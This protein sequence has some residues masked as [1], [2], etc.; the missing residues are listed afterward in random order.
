MTTY[1]RCDRC[2]Y[3]NPGDPWLRLKV[4]QSDEGKIAPD[5]DQID[6]CYACEADMAKWMAKPLVDSIGR[7]KT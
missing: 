5:S 6:L 2:G 1:M 3:L 4:C 7:V